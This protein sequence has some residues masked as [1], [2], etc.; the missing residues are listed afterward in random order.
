M[1]EIILTAVLEEV[2]GSVMFSHIDRVFFFVVTCF[3][4][5]N[6][7]RMKVNKSD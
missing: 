5:G 3:E 7:R 6:I 4:G 2:F 1:L